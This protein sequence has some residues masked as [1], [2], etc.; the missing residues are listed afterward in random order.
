M[1][2]MFCRNTSS[3]E[4]MLYVC[5]WSTKNK[6]SVSVS[7]WSPCVGGRCCRRPYTTTVTLGITYEQ[8]KIEL[9]YSTC[10]F[11]ET[12]PFTSYHDV[13][14][15]DLAFK[16]DL[17]FN[18]KTL[19]LAIIFKPKELGL[20]Y[21]ICTFHNFFTLKLDLLFKNVY[22][23]HSLWTVRVGAFIFHMCIACDK[24]FHVIS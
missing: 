10:V 1:F 6:A 17:L 16:F 7:V 20:S 5:I 2:E 21:C 11:L 23:G 13:W 9:S 24:T 3:S 12:R 14:P 19:T 4:L 22:L 8:Q 18:S 15:S